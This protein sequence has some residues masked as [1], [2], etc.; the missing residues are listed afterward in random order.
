MEAELHRACLRAWKALVDVCWNRPNRC[1]WGA[2]FQ[3]QYGAFP[4]VLCQQAEALAEEVSAEL[5]EMNRRIVKAGVVRA[6]ASAL[7]FLERG[8][9]VCGFPYRGDG[10]VD[11]VAALPRTDGRPPRWAA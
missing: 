1:T 10:G 9:Q 6:A 5:V 2:V 7:A 11:D 4:S 3:E 8:C